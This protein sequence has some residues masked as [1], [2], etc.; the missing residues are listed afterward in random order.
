MAPTLSRRRGAAPNDEP[1][2]SRAP[3]L[4]PV[5]LGD[6]RRDRSADRL[7]MILLQEMNAVP[8]LDEPA[9]LEPAGELLREAGAT[10]APGSAENSSFG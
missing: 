10:S 6:E 2:L 3:A 5:D 9:I 8:E 1:P 7:G 4:R